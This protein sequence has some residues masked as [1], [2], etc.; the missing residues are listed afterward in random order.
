MAEKSTHVDMIQEA[1]RQRYRRRVTRTATPVAEEK[2]RLGR[3]PP[4]LRKEWRLTLL[5]PWKFRE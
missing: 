2:P 1:T 5:K 3:W 4:P